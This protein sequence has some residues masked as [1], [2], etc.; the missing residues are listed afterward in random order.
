MLSSSFFFLTTF[1]PGN[2][3]LLVQ[4]SGSDNIGAEAKEADSPRAQGGQELVDRL[5]SRRILRELASLS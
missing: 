2:T 4:A 5:G 3:A 1:V